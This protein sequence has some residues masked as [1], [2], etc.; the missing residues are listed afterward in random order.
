MFGIQIQDDGTAHMFCD[1]KSAV[2]NSNKIEPSLS[3]T[4]IALEHNYVRW[5]VDTGVV[6][7][8]WINTG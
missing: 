4:N 6:N 3:K 1:N 8:Y 7:N 5:N 2:N